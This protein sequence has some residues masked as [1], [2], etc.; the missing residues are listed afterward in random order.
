[1]KALT[2]CQ[3]YAHLIVTGEKRVENRG[4]YCKHRGPVLIHAGKSRRW[5]DTYHPLPE[6]MVFGAIVGR[7]EVVACFSIFSIRHGKLWPDE[8]WM[9]THKHTEG[10]FCLILERIERL[11]EPIVYRGQQRLFNVPDSV[12]AGAAWINLEPPEAV[13]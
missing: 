13:A 8:R 10:P 6:G 4:W 9:R 1:M 12:L 2:V 5:L 3:P 11:I 7:V